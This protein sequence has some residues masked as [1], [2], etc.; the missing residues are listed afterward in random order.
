MAGV[1]G[2][3]SGGFWPHSQKTSRCDRCG[4]ADRTHLFG[5]LWKWSPIGWIVFRCSG[6]LSGKHQKWGNLEYEGTGHPRSGT[7]DFGGWRKYNPSSNPSAANVHGCPRL[8][9]LVVFLPIIVVVGAF[10][11]RGHPGQAQ[12]GPWVDRRFGEGTYREF[13]GVLRLELLFA[14]MCLGIVLSALA[15][16]FFFNTTI[17][18]PEI[19]G[20][21]VSGSV[22]FLAAYFIRRSRKN[23]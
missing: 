14:A 23:A 15:R 10:S 1:G 5:T 22:A 6:N 7:M 20:F 9:W 21:F 12:L 11:K 2:L 18:P 3:P 4:R 16:A 8:P 17:M 13:M 19:M